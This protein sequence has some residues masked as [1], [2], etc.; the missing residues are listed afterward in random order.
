MITIKEVNITSKTILLIDDEVSVREIVGLCLKDLGGWDVVIA[1][2]L[3]D[4]LQKAE[5][6]KFDAVVLDLSI[7]A[8]NSFRFIDKLRN[9]PQFQ[10]VP[11][12][13]LS[14]TRWI[15]PQILQRY[16]IAGVILKP[17]DPVTLSCDIAAILGWKSMPID[18]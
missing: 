3:L 18:D 5:L 13:L 14:A 10:A 16:Q 17:F 1:D 2:S 15:D 12:V 8:M 4:G 9:N 6:F 11:A 7:H